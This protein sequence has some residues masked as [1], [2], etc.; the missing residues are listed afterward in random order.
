MLF[1]SVGSVL[2][3]GPSGIDGRS[4]WSAAGRVMQ[5]VSPTLA[6]YSEHKAGPTVGR[7]VIAALRSGARYEGS[8]HRK[9]REIRRTIDVSDENGTTGGRFPSSKLE[10]VAL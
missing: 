7:L 5:T 1:R 3:A 9:L 8:L 10:L 6:N 4:I 2:P